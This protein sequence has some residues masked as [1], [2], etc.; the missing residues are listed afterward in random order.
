MIREGVSKMAE[1][2]SANIRAIG[3]RR[4][5]SVEWRWSDP[6]IQDEDFQVTDLSVCLPA[7]KIHEALFLLHLAEKT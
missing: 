1:S 2:D 6:L 7:A 4:I 5:H 3:Y